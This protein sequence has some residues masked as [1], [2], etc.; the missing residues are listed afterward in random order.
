MNSM[1][2]DLPFDIALDKSQKGSISG[3]INN[4]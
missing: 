2:V 3:F 1:Y 4:I